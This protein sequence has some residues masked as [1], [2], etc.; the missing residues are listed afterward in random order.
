MTDNDEEE[1]DVWDNSKDVRV[2]AAVSFEDKNDE[3]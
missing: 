1:F 2:A 3:L